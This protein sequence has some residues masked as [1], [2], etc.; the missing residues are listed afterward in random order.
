MNLTHG[1]RADKSFSG[2]IRLFWGCPSVCECWCR[3]KFAGFEKKL[4]EL[5]RLAFM[6]CIGAATTFR[7]QATGYYG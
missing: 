7:G 4:R 1:F 5:R 6:G 2:P 3:R